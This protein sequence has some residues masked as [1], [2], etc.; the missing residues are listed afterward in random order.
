M[1]QDFLDIQYLALGSGP[2]EQLEGPQQGRPRGLVRGPVVNLHTQKGLP[3]RA[4]TD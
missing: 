3:R 4:V 1:G 2:L